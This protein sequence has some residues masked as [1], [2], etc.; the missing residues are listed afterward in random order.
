MQVTAQELLRE[1][2]KRG[3][4]ERIEAKVSSEVGKSA[5]DNVRFAMPLFGISRSGVVR[6]L[7]SSP[8]Y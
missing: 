2:N 7:A 3:E 5:L 4:H 8:R 1:L 6:F